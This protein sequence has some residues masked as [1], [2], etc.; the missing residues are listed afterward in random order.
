V[1]WGKRAEPF[2][3]AGKPIRTY[4]TSVVLPLRPGTWYYRVRGLNLTLARGAQPLSWSDPVKVVVAK[5]RFKIV[6]K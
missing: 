3:A 1:Q 5:P 2:S 4:S 6:S